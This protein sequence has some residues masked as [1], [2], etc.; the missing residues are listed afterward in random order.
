MP[1]CKMVITTKST[2]GDLAHHSSTVMCVLVVLAGMYSQS[3]MGV[4]PS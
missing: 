2:E 4:A 3:F 1:P